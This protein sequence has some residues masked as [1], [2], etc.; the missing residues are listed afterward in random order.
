MKDQTCSV[1]FVL[2]GPCSPE[3]HV[4]VAA[5]AR[6]SA[7]RSSR[8][9]ATLHA[10]HGQRRVNWGSGILLVQPVVRNVC[11]TANAFV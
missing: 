10:R 2:V 11:D 9:K 3:K 4:V 1:A 6:G 7:G 5:L 8:R